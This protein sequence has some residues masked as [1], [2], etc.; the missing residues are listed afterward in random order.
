MSGLG[1]HP[2]SDTNYVREDS[3]ESTHNLI[4][5]YDI[6]QQKSTKKNQRGEKLMGVKSGRNQVQVLL[7]VL[8][9]ESHRTHLIPP[10]MSC[11]RHLRCWKEGSSLETECL[12]FYWGLVLH[13]ILSLTYQNFRYPEGNQALNINNIICKNIL[14]TVSSSSQFWKCW[15]SSQYLNS[16]ILAQGHPSKRSFY[17]NSRLTMSMIFCT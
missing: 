4:Q 14:V 7:R 1:Q 2:T 5:T 10:T 8:P 17:T 11:D 6:L 9:V 12:E 3:Q 13:H 15:E 16:H